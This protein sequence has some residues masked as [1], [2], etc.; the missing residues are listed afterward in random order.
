MGADPKSDVTAILAE[1][2]RDPTDPGNSPEQLLPLVYD[3]LRRLARSY[4]RRERADHTLQATALVHEAYERLAD[5]SRVD[6][7]GRTHFFAVAAQVMR[8]LLVDHARQRGRRKR[9]G[10]E[11]R[12]TLEGLAGSPAGSGLDLVELIALDRALTQLAALDAREAQVVEL[13]Y[14]GG[15]TTAEIASF[16]HVSE[17][18]VRNDWG[19]A[20]AWLKEKISQEA[21][22]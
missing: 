2:S 6:W 19:H 17:R 15:L 1:F 16:L 12:V 10:G 11:Q 7:R 22:V 3:E 21:G 8:R 5:Q 20:R 14:F 18:T 13:R 4:F 9:G